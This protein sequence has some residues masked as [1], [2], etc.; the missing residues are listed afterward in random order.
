MVK[1][2][3]EVDQVGV[4]GNTKM[5]VKRGDDLNLPLDPP[6]RGAGVIVVRC[7]P[8]KRDKRADHLQ[9]VFDPMI[10]FASKHRLVGDDRPQVELCH[11]LVGK[12]SQS[13]ALQCVERPRLIVEHA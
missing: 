11:D 2:G 4:A 6:E 12:D 7:A 13:L 10:D 3:P 5:L 1:I 8:F 9:R